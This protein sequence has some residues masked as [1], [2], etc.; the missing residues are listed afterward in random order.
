MNC[1]Y[2]LNL[3]NNPKNRSNY[4]PHFTGEDTE[5]TGLTVTW[6]AS[7]SNMGSLVPFIYAGNIRLGP[8]NEPD[9]VLGIGNPAANKKDKVPA[10][11]KHSCALVRV[12]LGF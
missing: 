10:I 9:S 5:V 11:T 2:N 3:L 7:D 12:R 8:Y 6:V 4:Y 1:K